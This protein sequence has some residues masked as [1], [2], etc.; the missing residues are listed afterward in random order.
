MLNE[1]KISFEAIIM[2]IFSYI[3]E[4]ARYKK[5]N[6][7]LPGHIQEFEY[8]NIKSFNILNIKH[9]ISNCSS[10]PEFLVMSLNRNNLKHDFSENSENS[11]HPE[12]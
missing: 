6:K 4:G 2:V 3:W 11:H 7:S 8:Y 10:T 5:G 9:K 1:R 12:V